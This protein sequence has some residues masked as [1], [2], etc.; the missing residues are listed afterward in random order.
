MELIRCQN[1]GNQCRIG[2]EQVGVDANGNPLIHRFSYCDNCR[3]KTDLDMA[4]AGMYPQGKMPV[5]KKGG[6]PKGWPI[7][8]VG[9]VIFLCVLSS[10]FGGDKNKEDSSKKEIVRTSDSESTEDEDSVKKEEEK[11]GPTGSK[12]QDKRFADVTIDEQELYD[13][14]DLK[15]VATEYVTDSIWG[16]GIK[17]LIENNKDKSIGIGCH[18]LIVNDYMITDLFS[19]TVASGK[20]AYETMN[21]SNMALKEAGI[22]NVGKV[23]MYL[24]TYDPDTYS[25]VDELGC[26]TVK[27][28]VY[29]S[30]DTTP[31]DLGAELYN[32]GGIRIV[33]KY[34]DENSFWG[35]AALLYIENN[36]GKNVKVHCDEMSVNGYMIT[37]YFYSEVYDGKKAIDSITMLS[38][39]LKES[40]IKQIE[41]IELN[42]RITDDNYNVIDESGPVSFGVSQ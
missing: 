23:E 8:A 41:E 21:F 40:D 34:V 26:I 11:I 16:D 5:K 12:E 19:T 36:C 24:Y 9:V 30:M 32:K 2:N 33:G 35:A 27:T 6:L 18:A 25:T 15:I 37:P 31:N 10:I 13:K 29:D 20:K 38:S 39:Q 17:L 22:D 28:S 14:D 1:C 4:N 42:F 3:T 7:L